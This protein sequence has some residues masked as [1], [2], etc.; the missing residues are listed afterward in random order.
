[1]NNRYLRARTLA[2]SRH[3]GQRYGDRPY[4]YHLDSVADLAQ[5]FG[6]DAMIVAQLHDL[7]EDT[8]TSVDEIAA[9][10]GFTIADA[11]MYL[12][13][14]S[15][16]TRSVRKEEANS[17]LRNLT[18]FEESARLALIV[19]ACDRLANVRASKMF[20]TKHLTRYREEHGAFRNACYRKGLCEAI[21]WELDN[22]IEPKGY[23]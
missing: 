8:E 9:E 15:E 14:S 4:S 19:K 17:R 22:L 12:T 23:A 5:P 1:M 3:L 11:V 10:F 6:S 16:I 21:W 13:D 18:V 20:S 2:R 7:L